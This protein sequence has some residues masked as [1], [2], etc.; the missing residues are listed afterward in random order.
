MDDLED[1]P[2]YAAYFIPHPRLSSITRED[3]H[4]T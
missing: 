4:E 3:G 1:R 2:E